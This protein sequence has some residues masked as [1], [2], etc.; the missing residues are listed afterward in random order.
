MEDVRGS[1]DISALSSSILLLSRMPPNTYILTQ[2]KLRI[3]SAITT[4]FSFSV[5]DEIGDDG[6]PISINLA[7]EGEVIETEQTT[8]SESAAEDIESWI[9]EQKSQGK[10][11][12]KSGEVKKEFDG[13][14]NIG[15]VR[16]ALNK[17]LKTNGIVKNIGKG[18]WKIL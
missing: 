5:T 12:F 18:K 16:D 17:I 13:I 11:T 9:E 10:T 3:G 4:P 7:Y 14:H 6:K 8:A 1:G 2:K 15:A